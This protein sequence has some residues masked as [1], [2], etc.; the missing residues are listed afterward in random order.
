M[1]QI[2]QT[3]VS[4]RKLWLEYGG[5]GNTVPI[6]SYYRSVNNTGLVKDTYRFPYNPIGILDTYY[7]PNNGSGGSTNYAR[8]VKIIR[9]ISNGPGYQAGDYVPNS[10]I[11]REWR[12]A[13]TTPLRITTTQN[14]PDTN[15]SAGAQYGSTGGYFY[16][17][18]DTNYPYFG[19]TR[20][21]ASMFV[22][23]LITP[24]AVYGVNIYENWYGLWRSR[25]TPAQLGY[26]N[27]NVPTSG[28]ISLGQF[29]GQQNP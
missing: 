17:V 22:A 16:F 15:P 25:G 7:T 4:M 26:Y 24:V 13:S 14:D 27:Q 6:D 10:D 21:I 8:Y 11:L 12:Y 1:A 23:Q 28:P 5:S 20:T 2:P 3:N 19:Q 9:Y 18:P 29:R